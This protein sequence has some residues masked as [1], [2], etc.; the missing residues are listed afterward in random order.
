MLPHRPFLRWLLYV[1]ALKR[2]TPTMIYG[3]PNYAAET[4]GNQILLTGRQRRRSK[5]TSIRFNV[6]RPTRKSSSC[7][8]QAPAT[9]P[10]D[11]RLLATPSAAALPPVRYIVVDAATQ[12]LRCS[13]RPAGHR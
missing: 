7:V 9:A 10:S 1:Q 4:R 3:Y 8:Q 13:E 5:R 11:P 12:S 6:I 2:P